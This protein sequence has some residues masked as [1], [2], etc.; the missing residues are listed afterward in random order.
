MTNQKHFAASDGLPTGP[1]VD[2]LIKHWPELQLTDRIS[3]TEI[4]ALLGVKPDST[5]FRTVTIRWRKRWLDQGIVIECAKGHATFYV[6]NLNQTTARTHDVMRSVGRKA[7]RHRRKLGS[8]IAR[9]NT[10]EP[11]RATAEHHMRLLGNVEREAKKN[12]KNLLPDTS[13]KSGPRILPP[14]SS[15]TD[16]ERK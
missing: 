2:L 3:Y 8:L 7:H 4:A 16:L 13:V 5:R 6:A 11:E 1:D 12:R 15:T 14:P 9:P 10:N